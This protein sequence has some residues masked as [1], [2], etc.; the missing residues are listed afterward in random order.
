MLFQFVFGF[1]WN[2][3]DMHKVSSFCC[4]IVANYGADRYREGFF[5]IAFVVS[6]LRCNGNSTS[7]NILHRIVDSFDDYCLGE[8]ADTQGWE[9][10][11]NDWREYVLCIFLVLQFDLN[12]DFISGLNCFGVLLKL[13]VSVLLV[14]F[15]V[16]L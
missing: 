1:L 6:G 7:Q 12:E 15:S 13:L 5:A 11:L 4:G 2:A 16:L 9:G 8:T 3:D 14:S 10:T